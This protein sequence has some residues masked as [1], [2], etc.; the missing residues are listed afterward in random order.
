MDSRWRVK[1]FP[2]PYHRFF[3]ADCRSLAQK[4]KEFRG[5][6][7]TFAANTLHKQQNRSTGRGT[8]AACK[9]PA[10]AGEGPVQ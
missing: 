5:V 7:F 1:E 2:V 10:K 4:S 9:S 6:V 3:A 8:A